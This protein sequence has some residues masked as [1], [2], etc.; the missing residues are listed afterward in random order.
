MPLGLS[1]SGAITPTPISVPQ[2]PK[3]PSFANLVAAVKPAVVNISTTQEVKS[4]KFQLPENGP[5]S[6]MLRQLLGPD[7][8]K[9]LQ[10]RSQQP[11][12]AR[13]WFRHR[14]GRLRRHQQP[15]LR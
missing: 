11:D 15:R 1:A 10:Q 9:Q 3:L 8:Q 2:L 7:W 14:P 6:D 5:L 13:L 12:H 4:S